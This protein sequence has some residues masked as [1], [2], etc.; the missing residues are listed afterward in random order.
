MVHLDTPASPFYSPKAIGSHLLQHLD[1]SANALSNIPI[2]VTAFLAIL[3]TGGP[4][5]SFGVYAATLKSTFDLS[6]SQLETLG[7]AS[8]AAGFISWIPGL[9]VDVWGSKTALIVGGSL[10]SCGLL[11]YWLCTRWW[12]DAEEIPTILVV[13]LL[14]FLSVLIFSSNNLVIGG[15]F[16]SIVVSCG[17]GTKGKAVGAAKAYLGL[18]AGVFSCL[19][20]S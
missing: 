5:Y 8:F 6:Q 14:A 20:K 19:F 11:S 16:K 18:G 7:S 15:V 10:Q 17:L 2:L 9:C 3:S 12:A 4:T 13:P 1:A